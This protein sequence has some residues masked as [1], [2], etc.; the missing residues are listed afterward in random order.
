[1]PDPA[2]PI[3]LISFDLDDTLWPCAPVIQH[4]EQCLFDWLQQTARRI[5][6]NHNILTLRQHRQQ[7]AQQRPMLAHDMTALRIHSLRMLLAEHGYPDSLAEEA[8]TV[9]LSARNTV[10]PYTEVQPVLRALQARFHLVSITNGN[11]EVA[12]TPLRDC[13]HASYTA[14]GVGAAKPD[15]ALFLRAMADARVTPEQCLH[16]GDDPQRDIHAAQ[17]LG[18]QTL[19][20]NREQHEWPATLPSPN[21]VFTD[22]RPLPDWLFG[23]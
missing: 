17:R 8:M 22:L 23:R 21:A 3:R 6:E 15:P 14:A 1:M 19:W 11:A 2:T 13:F 20:I 5:T 4:A 12:C 7:L 18:M 16:V 10:L 9:F